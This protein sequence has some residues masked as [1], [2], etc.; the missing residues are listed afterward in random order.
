[1]GNSPTVARAFAPG[2]VTGLFVPETLGK[3]KLTW[4][5][6]GAGLV[7][8]RGVLATARRTSGADGLKLRSP[9][10]AHALTITERALSALLQ[11]VPGAGGLEVEIVHDLPIS[12]GLGMSAAGTLAATMAAA[13]VLGLPETSAIA[14]AHL[15]EIEGHGG[16]GGIPAILGDGIEVRRSPG[17]PPHGVV[18]RTPCAAPITLGVLGKAMESPPLLSDPKFLAKVRKIGEGLM[19]SLPP[20]PLEL[21]HLLE[22]SQSFAMELGLGEPRIREALQFCS[23][24]GFLASQAMLG[25]TIFAPMVDPETEAQLERMGFLVYRLK[26][27][28]RGA[29]LVA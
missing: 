18:E 28:A 3:E 4:G 7:L 9:A 1:M 13:R 22:V 6:R 23:A 14:Q 29:N 16:L 19:E 25:N 15:A 8:D 26:V 24:R 20:P 12:R 5:S 27:G 17:L 21:D 10:G 2:H 11:E